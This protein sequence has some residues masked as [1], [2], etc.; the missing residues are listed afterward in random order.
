M[1]TNHESTIQILF[2]FINNQIKSSS[3]GI[4]N[5]NERPTELNYSSIKTINMNSVRK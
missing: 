3:N 2:K 4:E 1:C 5:L